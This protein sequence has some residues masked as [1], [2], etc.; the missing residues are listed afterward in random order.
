MN[1]KEI[2]LSELTHI[3][4]LYP[5]FGAARK[6]LAARTGRPADA[7]LYVVNRS[8][9]CGIRPAK[10]AAKIDREA[11]QKKVVVV[12][13]DYFTQQEYDEVSRSEDRHFAS[14]SAKQE[15]ETAAADALVPDID[16]CTET[17]AEI[18]REQGYIEQAANIYSKLSLRYP[19]KNAYFAAL[20]EK[21]KEEN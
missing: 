7:A 10:T 8:V 4:N 14:F 11:L 3:V 19:E 15:K 16:F 5:W 21:L 6:E 12:G 9:L 17:L 18:Y 1:L 20:I 2:S 13:G